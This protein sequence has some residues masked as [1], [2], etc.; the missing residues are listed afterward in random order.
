PGELASRRDAPPVVMACEWIEGALLPCVIL[1]N[2]RGTELAARHLAALG[3]A[4]LACIGGPPDNVLH[5]ARLAGIARLPELS[6]HRF[7][8][9][10]TLEAGSRAALAWRSLPRGERP[11]AVIAFSDEMACGF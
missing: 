11:S 1:D 2:A 6:L 3:H 10:F 5:A 9:D 8:G 4:R 7:A